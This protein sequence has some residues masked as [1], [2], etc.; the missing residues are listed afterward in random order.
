MSP[1]SA[2]GA[3]AR[4]QEALAALAQGRAEDAASA[5]EGLLHAR[6][7]DPDALAALAAVRREQRR[8]GDAAALLER[9]LAARPQDPSAWNNLGALRQESGD[10]AGAAAAFERALALQPD[11]PNALFNLARL[12]APQQPPERARALL[13]RL[14]ALT[15]RDVAAWNLLGMVQCDC[16]AVDAGLASLARALELAPGAPDILNNL[17]V[18]LAYAG[19]VDE[20]R[21]AY[22]RAVAAAPDYA[23]GWENLAHSRRFTHADRERVAHMRRL[24]QRADPRSR[25]ALC[26]HFALGKALD[27]LDEPEAAFAHYRAG[28]ELMAANVRYDPREHD[29]LVDRIV[30]VCDRRFV[31]RCRAL[32]VQGPR[33]V[34]VVGMPRSGTTLVEQ[35]VGRSPGLHAAGELRVVEHAVARAAGDAAG[36]Y[37]EALAAAPDDALAALA[38]ALAAGYASVTPRGSTRVIDKMPANYLLLGVVHA[39]LPG[40]TVVHCRRDPRDTGL[41]LYFQHFA[42]GQEFS[43]SLEHIASRYRA[44]RRTMAHWRALMGDRLVEVDYDALVQQPEAVSRRLFSDAGLEWTPDCLS[45]PRSGRVV[46]TASFWQVRRPISA[47]SSGRWRR[48]A[49]WLGPLLALEA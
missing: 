39:L 41:S 20:A 21:D 15:P 28:N 47:S 24:V 12:L 42:T 38:Q 35:I 1:P 23:R 31:E 26:L 18:A 34:L 8:P 29:A 43:Y 11:S 2:A 45:P 49:P 19:R 9:A 40:A 32:A 46:R 25:D 22:E 37:P 7:G 17:G 6:P 13:E 5:L 10:P 44:Y 27:D 36:T 4:V 30:A 3:R 14:V 16:D 48:F 33:P